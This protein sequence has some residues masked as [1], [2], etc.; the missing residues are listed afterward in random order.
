MPIKAEL[1]YQP[2]PPPPPSVVLTIPANEA[3]ALLSEIWSRLDL[4]EAPASVALLNAVLG[5]LPNSYR[6]GKPWECG[7]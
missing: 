5:V 7:Y 4:F 2:I 3:A 1:K 6:E